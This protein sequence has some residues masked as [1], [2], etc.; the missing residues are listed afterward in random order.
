[1]LILN[2]L[3]STICCGLTNTN[4]L[5]YVTNMYIKPATPLRNLLY[6]PIIFIII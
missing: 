1:M 5:A 2:R 3:R 4:G 6:L